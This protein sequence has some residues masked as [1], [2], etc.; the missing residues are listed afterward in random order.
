MVETFSHLLS[1]PQWS[2]Q[3][4]EP[5]VPSLNQIQG[6]LGFFREELML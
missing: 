6:S 5:E 2:G 4:D 3:G 1:H